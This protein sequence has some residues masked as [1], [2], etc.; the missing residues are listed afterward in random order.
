[1]QSCTS[2]ANLHGPTQILP[3][4]PSLELATVGPP[5]SD[6]FDSGPVPGR[7]EQ[8]RVVGDERAVERLC[9]RHVRRVV[10]SEVRAVFPDPRN[11][12]PM[13][14]TVD[15]ERVEI[16]DRLTSTLDSD[17]LL[18]NESTKDLEHLEVDEVRRVDVAVRGGD[19]RVDPRRRMSVQE[20]LE[21][22]RSIKDDHRPSRSRRTAAAVSIPGTGVRVANRLRSSANVGSSATRSISSMR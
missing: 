10:G 4:P 12:L 8:P 11:E 18:A 1:M 19:A 6:Q 9:Q 20:P 13:A 17:R 3:N 16:L 14:V 2:N 22:G 5:G 7:S 15:R 21:H